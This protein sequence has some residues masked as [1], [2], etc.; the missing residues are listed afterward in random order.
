MPRAT[1]LAMLVVISGA[2]AA[3]GQQ[4]TARF[5]VASVKRNLSDSPRASIQVPPAGTL[6]YTNVPL[7]V[8]IRDA[9][10]VDPYAEAYRLIAGPYARS[11]GQATDVRWR[12]FHATT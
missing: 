5:E 6:T 12:P 2:S 3:V 7:R 11:I 9:Y 10:Q 1:L 8:L 4:P